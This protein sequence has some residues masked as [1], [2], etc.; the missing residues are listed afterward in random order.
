MELDPHQLTTQE[1]FDKQSSYYGSSHQ[2]LSQL[3]DLKFLLQHI[4][5]PLHAPALD[6]ATG[7]GHAAL[8]LAKMGYEVT[9]S[10]ISQSMLDTAAQ[11][12]AAAGFSIHTKQHP[13]EELP[14]P[15]ASFA[16]VCCR[17]AAHHF[18]SPARFIQEAARVLKTGG[19]FLVVD[20]TVPDDYPEAAE[21]LDQ[22]EKFRDP[23]HVRLIPPAEWLYLCRRA[24]LAPQFWQ[25]TP[26]KQPDL[27]AHFCRANT[28]EENRQKVLQLVENA[29]PIVRS[30]Y[31]L[32]REEGKVTWFWPRLGLIARKL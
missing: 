2:I 14:Y 12:A 25:V 3:E 13:A 27:E 31:S 9:A 17:V 21:W 26:L 24:G 18:T 16:L 15:D 29:S 28:S 4:S 7:G 22:V 8:F 23:S 32:G 5:L 6:I 10:D 1:H 20:T 30:H 11:L 19:A